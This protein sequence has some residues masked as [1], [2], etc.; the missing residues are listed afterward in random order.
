MAKNMPIFYV[1][2]FSIVQFLSISDDEEVASPNSKMNSE[3]PFA[4]IGSNETIIVNNKKVEFCSGPSA[5][6]INSI[7]SSVLD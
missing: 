2:K 4:V 1:V 5:I 6:G 7:I 3:I